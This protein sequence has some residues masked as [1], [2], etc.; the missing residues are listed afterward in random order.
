MG[1]RRVFSRVWQIVLF[2]RHRK[3][4]RSLDSSYRVKRRAHWEIKLIVTKTINSCS[5]YHVN[6]KHSSSAI[7]II[8]FTRICTGI[9]HFRHRNS[10]LKWQI[11]E[12]LEKCTGV[13]KSVQEQTLLHTFKRNQKST[14]LRIF[15]DGDSANI[16]WNFILIVVSIIQTSKNERK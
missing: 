1:N 3:V 8:V 2:G 13:S 10:C 7:V 4:G 16:T 11:S 14:I 9:L 15:F 12:N 6:I 5:L